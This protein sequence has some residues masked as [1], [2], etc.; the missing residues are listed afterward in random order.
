MRKILT[1]GMTLIVLLVG[2][3]LAQNPNEIKQAAKPATEEQ[4]KEETQKST[5]TFAETTEWLQRICSIHTPKS[6]VTFDGY[7]ISAEWSVGESS[8]I[9]MESLAII[10]LSAVSNIKITQKIVVSKTERVGRNLVETKTPK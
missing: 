1:A 3:G 7:N 5:A 4:V 6:K 10:P 9:T 2:T 8:G